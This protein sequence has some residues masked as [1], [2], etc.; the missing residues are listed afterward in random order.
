MAANFVVIDSS[1]G[2][3]SQGFPYSKNFAT[4][5]GIFPV[6]GQAYL[7]LTVRTGYTSILESAAVS[8][9]GA[10]IGKIIPRPFTDPSDWGLQTEILVFNN[11]VLRPF[12][13]TL[14]IIPQGGLGD[15]NNYL[16]LG[17]TICHYFA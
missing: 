17:D 6:S 13:Q 4:A 16:L 3:I 15:P 9:R 8:I 7:I 12:F 5:T 14:Q 10:T 1:S 11:T 2:L